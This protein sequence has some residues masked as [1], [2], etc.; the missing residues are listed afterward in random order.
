MEEAVQ[1]QKSNERSGFLTFI[2]ILY[3]L[4][5]LVLGVKLINSILFL[6]VSLLVDS[7]VNVV[8]SL[9]IGI[10]TTV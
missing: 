9:I 6:I 8:L 10:R 3:L 1:K 7:S 2:F 5:A 4:G